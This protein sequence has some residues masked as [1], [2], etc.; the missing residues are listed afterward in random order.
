MKI[1]NVIPIRQLG[2]NDKGVENLDV[3]EARR[4]RCAARDRVGL[5]RTGVSHCLH[6]AVEGSEEVAAAMI[7]YAI[8]LNVQAHDAVRRYSAAASRW[9]AFENSIS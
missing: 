9:T 7:D 1:S 5:L 2:P 4:I 3:E 6:I 8:D